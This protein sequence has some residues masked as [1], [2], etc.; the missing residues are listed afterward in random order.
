MPLRPSEKDRVVKTLLSDSTDDLSNQ[1]RT[2]IIT[3][4]IESKDGSNVYLKKDE[5]KKLT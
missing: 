2:S 1:E 4:M 3:K 5:K